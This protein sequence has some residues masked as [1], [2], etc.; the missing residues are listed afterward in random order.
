[1]T[2]TEEILRSR[3]GIEIPRSLGSN[4]VIAA[5]NVRESINEALEWAATVCESGADE[6]EQVGTNN[7]HKQD[8]ANIRAG[9]SV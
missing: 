1:M 9:K 2:K 6:Y 3:C 8:A 5:D 4:V 7:A